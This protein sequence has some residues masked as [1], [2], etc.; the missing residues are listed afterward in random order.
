LSGVTAKSIYVSP[1]GTGSG[2]LDSPYGSI[3]TAVNAAVA[4]DTIF[5]RG[6]TYAPSANIQVVKNAT[7]TAPISVRPYQSEKVIIDGENM[8]G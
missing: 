2:T 4:G 1:T 6:G 3:Q 8:P 7:R 5:L